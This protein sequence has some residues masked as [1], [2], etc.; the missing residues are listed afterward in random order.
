M[1]RVALS[2]LSRLSEA[3][4]DRLSQRSLSLKHRFD[5]LARQRHARQR[6]EVLP[7]ISTHSGNRLRRSIMETSVP[8]SHPPPLTSGVPGM[9]TPSE[10]SYYGYVTQFY[11]GSGAIVELGPWLGLSTTLVVGGL[12][13]NPHFRDDTDAKIHVFDNFVWVSEWM[14]PFLRD[15]ELTTPADG[16][17][18]EHLFDRVT[19]PV[20]DRVAAKRR[21]IVSDLDHPEIEVLAWDGGP[22]QMIIVDCGRWLDVNNGWW[23]LLSPHFIQDETLIVMQDWQQYKT[24]PQPFWE[25]TKIFTDS[26]LGALDL[27]HELRD[28]GLATF[29]YR[30]R[31]K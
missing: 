7:A 8:W 15:S 10:R 11:N 13:Q 14:N 18:F 20:A 29:V 30:G 12:E 4:L 28:A 16:D 22:I 9:L 31:Q 19:Q 25:Q 2:G 6:P 3:Q 1:R 26:K 5:E 21:A 27:V 23:S 17:S 24:V